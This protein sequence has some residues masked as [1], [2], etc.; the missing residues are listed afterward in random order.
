M[1]PN[2]YTKKDSPGLGF[3]LAPEESNPF[4]GFL[5][6]LR[7]HVIPVM[8]KK[9]KTLLSFIG[10]FD[11]RQKVFDTTQDSKFLCL[12]YPANNPEILKKKS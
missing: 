3:L 10:G 2:C 5:L 11:N 4:D 9:S 7:V 1:G 8:D 6:Q 12:L